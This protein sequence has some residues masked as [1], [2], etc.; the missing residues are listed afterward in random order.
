[1]DVVFGRVLPQ[2]HIRHKKIMSLGPCDA[3]TYSNYFQ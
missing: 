1:M 2:Q 3:E